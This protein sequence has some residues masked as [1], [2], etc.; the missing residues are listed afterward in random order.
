MKKLLLAVSVLFVSCG[1][2]TKEKP[3]EIVWTPVIVKKK[4][5]EN[6]VTKDIVFGTGNWHS[7]N[8]YIVDKNNK[9][10]SGVKKDDFIICDVGDTLW[11]NDGYFL[12]LN[13]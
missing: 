6:D 8:Y 2:Q 10:W 1:E 9:I 12:Q 4:Y 3:K 5:S 11:T 7:T 13:K